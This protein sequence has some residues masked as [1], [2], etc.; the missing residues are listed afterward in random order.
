MLARRPAP[1]RARRTEARG[2]RLERRSTVRRQVPPP[3]LPT[4]IRSAAARCLDVTGAVITLVLLA[5]LFP[6]VALAI[7]LGG[8]GPV[9]YR[10]RRI[11]IHTR[12]FTIFKFRTLKTHAEATIGPRLLR[13]EDA[14]VTPVGRILRELKLDELPQL[15]NVLKGDMRLVGPRPMRPVLDARYRHAAIPGYA[16]RFQVKP[17]LT[18]LAQ[19]QGDY[20]SP[21]DEK[22]RW[23]AIYVQRRALSLDVGILLATTLV[24]LIGLIR[25]LAHR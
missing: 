20:Y 15:W 13:E 24:P 5:P 3:Q 23:D 22:V 16:T 6:L 19:V 12:A 2:P 9:L 17:G 25:L 1:E 11:G 14:L 8:A 18:G 10:G 21:I 4:R 7:R